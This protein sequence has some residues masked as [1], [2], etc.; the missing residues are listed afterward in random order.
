MLDLAVIGIGV[1]S[2]FYVKTNVNNA[3]GQRNGQTENSEADN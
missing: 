2:R 1:G 3:V